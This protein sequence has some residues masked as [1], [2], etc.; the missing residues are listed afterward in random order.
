MRNRAVARKPDTISKSAFAGPAAIFAFDL[1]WR[2][3]ED[4]RHF[5]LLVRKALLRDTLKASSRV[6][7]TQHFENHL[8]NCGRL[9]SNW[10]RR[11]S[12]L[13]TAHRLMS[14]A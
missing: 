12:S 1:L 10:R 13:K 7:Y 8:L 5:P 14:G 6:I 9:P 11:A 3:G 4:Y 2:D